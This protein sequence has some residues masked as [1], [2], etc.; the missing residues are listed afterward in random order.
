[1]KA[2][3]TTL[4]VFI[5]CS[6]H[7]Q[8]NP[9]T[10]VDSEAKVYM[11]DKHAVGLSIGVI[12]H[13]KSYTYNYGLKNL[14]GP[15]Q[16]TANA[17]YCIGSI[18]KT[19]VATLL[20]KAVLGHKASLQDDIR[21]YLPDSIN[22]DNL[23]Y[24]QQP[25]RLIHLSNHTSRISSQLAHLPTNWNNFSVDEKYAF[26]KKYTQ[27]EF[28]QDLKSVKID[29]LPG[30]KYEYSN[31]AVKL[32]SI[33][34]ERI[35]QKPFAELIGKYF[36]GNLKMQDTKVFLDK[37]AWKNFA[38][39]A[40]DL[41]VLMTTKDIDDFTS[42]PVVNSTVNDM[43]AY[44]F[45]QISEK[46]KAVQLTH[47]TTYTNADKVEIGLAWSIAYT[48]NG[49][50]YFYHSGSGWGCNSICI[51][52]PAKKIAVIVMAN[53]AASQSKLIALGK[54]IFARMAVTPQ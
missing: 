5:C 19:F 35:Y 45:Y 22:F 30:C 15:E 52:S 36:A 42:G 32:L 20:A 39:G 27:R 28:L 3:I 23:Q 13:A 4:L 44:L 40:Q 14:L 6:I 29:T 51:F 25:I 12:D 54:N 37:T 11:A 31:A 46:D 7:A 50:K 33:I 1:M 38:N 18:S 24:E 47:K 43:L 53:E 10:I 2:I 17:M 16:P 48:P 8:H 41:N 34:L 26:K 9:D 49:E 21:K